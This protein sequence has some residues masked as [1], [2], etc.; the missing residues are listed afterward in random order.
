MFDI[1]KNSCDGKYSSI[2]VRFTKKCDNDCSFCIEKGGLDSLGKPNVDEL[3]K[4]TISSNL[5]DVLVLG[6]EPFLYPEEL[7]KYIKG[8]R[9]HATDI[10][11]SGCEGFYTI[12]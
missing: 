12:Q 9:E 5:K 1:K 6:G 11:I 2:D 7:L 4:S 3:I 8:I 10:Y